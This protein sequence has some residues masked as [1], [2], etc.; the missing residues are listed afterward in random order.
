MAPNYEGTAVDFSGMSI[1]QIRDPV[2]AGSATN[3]LQGAAD[4][5]AQVAEKLTAACDDLHQLHRDYSSAHE[6]AAADATRDY[7]V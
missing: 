5:L 4:L 7:L 2:I 3:D 1:E 6:G